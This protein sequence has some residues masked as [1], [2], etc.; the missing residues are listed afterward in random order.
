MNRI[1][2]LNRKAHQIE[3]APTEEAA[4]KLM[5]MAAVPA[6]CNS[7]FDPGWEMDPFLGVAGLCQPMEADLFGCSD[8][9]WWPAQIP[10]TL[11]SFPDWTDGSDSASR[12]WAKLQSVFPK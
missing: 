11:H 9:C 2:P 5:A 4:E 3:T 7:T 8:A 6:G 10:D 12:D 1:K